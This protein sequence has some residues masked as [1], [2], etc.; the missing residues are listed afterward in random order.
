MKNLFLIFCAFCATSFV[1]SSCDNDKGMTD[2]E[3]NAIIDSTYEAEATLIRE[4][5]IRQCSDEMEMRVQ[6]KVDSIVQAK[7]D[8]DDESADDMLDNDGMTTDQDGDD[9]TADEDADVEKD[10]MTDQEKIDMAVQEKIAELREEME[11]ECQQRVMDVANHRAD[12]IL[13]LEPEAST[14]TPSS[15]PGNQ[16]EEPTTP[17]TEPGRKSEETVKPGRKSDE[18]VKPGRK[19][20]KNEGN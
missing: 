16:T 6:P 8:A 13:A 11:R 12:S 2:A 7:M 5:M 20:P 15:P 4:N 18:P 3:R 14:G 1:L 17:T 10:E 9:M 19:N